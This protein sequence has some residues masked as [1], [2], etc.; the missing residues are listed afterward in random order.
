[1]TPFTQTMFL[2]PELLRLALVFAGGALLIALFRKSERRHLF[3]LGLLYVLSL[4]LRCGAEILSRNDMPDT[5]RN[6]DVVALAVQAVAFVYLAAVFL[7]GVLL[8]ALRVNTPRILRDLA[9][10][11][12]CLAA[13]LWVLSVRHVDVMGIV[14]TS[15][16]L[17]AVIGFSLQ[18]TLANVMGGIALQLDGS[19]EVGDWVRFGEVSGIVREISWRHTSIETRNGDTLIVPNGVLMKNAILLEGK[20]AD[21]PLQERRWV[22]FNVDYRTPPTAVVDTVTDALCREPIPQMSRDPLPEVILTDFKESWAQYAVRYWLTDIM[23]SDAV[24]SV[25]RTRVYFALKRA[26]I[27]LSIPA[28]SVFVTEEDEARRKHREQKEGT[29]RLEALTGVSIFAP[30]TPEERA[31]L[32]QDLVFSPFAPKEAIVV[33]GSAV[34][35]LYILTKGSAEVRVSVEGGPSRVVSTLS[36]P[37]FFGEMGMLTGAPRKATVIAL[38]DVACWRVEKEKFQAILAARPAIADDI[39]RIIASRDVELAAV[40]EGLSEEAKRARLAHEHGS[41]LEKMQRFFGLS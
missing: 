28:Q 20:R 12:S 25:V 34:H 40:R 36:A 10:A 21:A 8:P 18:D 39:S 23:R 24:D 19:V 5:A 4:L 13:L 41:L 3:H 26:G 30:L 1:M 9:V 38:T 37:D 22:T 11:L 29:A 35:H 27:T 2:T 15:A 16:V 17:T 31:R 7:F 32:A 6:L 14:A 33:Q